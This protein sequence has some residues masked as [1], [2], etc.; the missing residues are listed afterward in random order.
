VKALNLV[1]LFIA[2]AGCSAKTMQG[3]ERLGELRGRIDQID[4]DLVRLLGARLAV[5]RDIGAVKKEMG[6]PVV[7]PAREAQVVDRFVRMAA[8]DGVPEATARAIITSLIAASR[9]QQ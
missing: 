9:A 1:I 6:K 7:D 4:A 3:E 5:A 8:Q 2:L